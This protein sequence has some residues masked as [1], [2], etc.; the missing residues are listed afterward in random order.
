ML[1]EGRNRSYL[2][3]AGEE[4]TQRFKDV[5]L[6]KP[7]DTKNTNMIIFLYPVLLD[8]DFI[9]DDDRFVWAKQQESWGERKNKVVALMKGRSKEDSHLGNRVQ[10]GC[11]V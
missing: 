10:K 7:D 11:K 9:L 1:K 6:A 5:I 8:S 4:A 2:T 3:V